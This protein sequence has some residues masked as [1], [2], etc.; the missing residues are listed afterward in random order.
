MSIEFGSEIKT[1]LDVEEFYF[2]NQSIKSEETNAINN[3]APSSFQE[4]EDYEPERI[5]KATSQPVIN[6]DIRS[7]CR[8]CAA[9]VND[10]VD[11]FGPNKQD[12]NIL[13]KI[14]HCLPIVVRVSL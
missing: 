3:E 10:L 2:V 1:E 8:L 7:R 14:Q 9:Q 11:M 6:T 12:P 5:S 4:Y 13:E